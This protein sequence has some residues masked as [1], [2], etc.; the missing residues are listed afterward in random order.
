MKLLEMQYQLKKRMKYAKLEA[1]T[2]AK[3]MK[4]EG[5]EEDEA[6]PNAETG[7][8]SQRNVEEEVWFEEEEGFEGDAGPELEMEQE[9]IWNAKV[10]EAERRRKEGEAILQHMFQF[11]DDAMKGPLQIEG[12]ISD[13][14]SGV[15]HLDAPRFLLA[16]CSQAQS[17]FQAQPMCL[18]LEVPVTIVGDLHGQYS[19][20]V[21]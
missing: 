10:E 1:G 7:Q 13:L 5:A 18:D 17:V 6:G 11:I 3:R 12:L 8:E 2:A 9:T 15:D 14:V 4:A 19:R 21:N 16:L 20:D